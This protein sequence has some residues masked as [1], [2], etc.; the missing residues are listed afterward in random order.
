MPIGGIAQPIGRTPIALT[1]EMQFET[2][3]DGISPCT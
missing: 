3:F 2:D 1:I